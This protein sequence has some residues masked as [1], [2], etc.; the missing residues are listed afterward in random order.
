MSYK[1]LSA[2]SQVG[3]PGVSK[4]L[5]ILEYWNLRGALQRLIR[6]VVNFFMGNVMRNLDDMNHMSERR[7]IKTHL[8]FY[9]LPPNLL[10]TSKVALFANIDIVK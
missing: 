4:F 10:E 9:L 1:L 6:R 8:P 5:D 3:I 7:V 2:N